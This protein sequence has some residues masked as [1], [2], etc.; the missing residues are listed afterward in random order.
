MLTQFK[1]FFEKAGSLALF[2][3]R[4]MWCA[5]KIK[6]FPRVRFGAFMVGPLSR[7]SIDE[8]DKLYASINGG[9]NLGFQKKALLWLLAPRLCLVA[10]D[11]HEE[12]VAMTLFYFNARDQAEGT[13][14]ASYNGMCPAARGAGLGTFLL[15]HALESFAR[16]GLNGASSRVS[17]N[18]PAALQTNGKA[19]F[20]PVE[21]YFDPMMGEER[22]YLVCNLNRYKNP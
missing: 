5:R 7:D 12:I 13:V 18:N 9:E 16:S 11:E 19:G 14:H 6:P 20:I 1:E 17:L 8:A 2:F 21:T 22:H 10:R 3:V 4:N 15:R